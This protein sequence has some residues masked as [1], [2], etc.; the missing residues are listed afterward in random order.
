MKFN[1]LPVVISVEHMMYMLLLSSIYSVSKIPGCYRLFSLNLHNVYFWKIDRKKVLFR[2]MH[3][4]IWIIDICGD[5]SVVNSAWD[6]NTVLHSILK[7]SSF[8]IC[9]MHEHCLSKC[10]LIS[11][12]C[13][14][15]LCN[16]LAVNSFSFFLLNK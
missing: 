11:G 3:V 13:S 16:I 15:L 7:V 4:F 5:N 1:C 10:Q 9:L 14:S 12:W 6:V 8:V 2:I